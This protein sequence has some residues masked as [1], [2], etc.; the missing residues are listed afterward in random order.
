MT[1]INIYK[2]ES[3]LKGRRRGGIYKLGQKI[4]VKITA[5]FPLERKINL[6]ISNGK[7]NSTN[8]RVGF[9]SIEMLLK[10][11]PENIK[12]IFVP[13]NRND[14]RALSLIS[15]AEKLICFSR[16]KKKLKPAP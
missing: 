7:N 2:I 11:S 13:A 16:K 6:V 1:D 5:I 8:L 12:K 14:D 9:H 15:M 10:L 3:A 4:K